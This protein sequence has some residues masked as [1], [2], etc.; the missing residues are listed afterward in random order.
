MSKAVS[1]SGFVIGATHKV[2]QDYARSGVTEDGLVYAIVCDGC[3]Q[4]EDSDVGARLLARA[5]ENR[6]GYQDDVKGAVWDAL[7]SVYPDACL[8]AT[9]LVATHT[10]GASYIR[11]FAWG[12][13]VIATRRRDGTGWHIWRIDYVKGAPAYQ[14]YTLDPARLEA[15]A[16]MSNDGEFTLTGWLAPDGA[17]SFVS[18]LYGVNDS[19]IVPVTFGLPVSVYDVVMVATDGAFS[20]QKLSTETRREWVQH[21]ALLP[22]VQRMTDPGSG[23]ENFAERF[24]H[25]FVADRAKENIRPADDVGV[26]VIYIPE[27]A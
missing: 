20:W 3:S 9:L 25:K 17:E 13:G 8:D 10:P 4:T 24:L 5:A 27:E 23:T 16:K 12:D 11:V 14:S 15:Y 2:C 22:F 26:G 18:T 7:T 21:D 19:G 1:S 6:L